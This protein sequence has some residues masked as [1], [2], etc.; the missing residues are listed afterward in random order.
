MPILHFFSMRLILL[1]LLLL[2]LL[3]AEF[4]L[5]D[6]QVEITNI[7]KDGSAHVQETVRFLVIGDYEKALYESG[8]DKNDLSF[9]STAMNIS[10]IRLH[11]N[12]SQVHIPSA[13]FAIR[14]QPLR[15]CN[16][17]LN[18]CQGELVL[19]YN[20]YPIHN[21]TSLLPLADTGIFTVDSSKP[22]TFRYA[23]NPDAFAFA[24]TER[25]DLRLDE[26][27]HL[28]FRIPAG[29]LFQKEE[30]INPKPD[31]FQETAFPASIPE[32][33]WNNLVLVK[34]TVIFEVEE[35]LDQEVVAFFSDLFRAVEIQ[36]RGEQGIAWILIGVLLLGSYLYLQKY[37]RR[38]E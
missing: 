33:R 11:L 32:L 7:Q 34:F 18:L 13:E 37:V 27:I 28:M 35:S 25:G 36:L 19:E 30:D 10:E 29:A 21:Q 31:D 14:P 2:S 24:T 16:P 20:A 17:S 23:L 3:H 6:V 9:W 26:N 1:S 12:P 22:R 38:K 5:R 8:F 4:V 15:K